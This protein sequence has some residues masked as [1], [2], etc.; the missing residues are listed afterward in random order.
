MVNVEKERDL[1]L[2]PQEIY[3]I[4]DLSTKVS[5]VNG[6]LNRFL[7]E[8]ALYTY[9]TIFLN[10]E[11]ENDIITSAAESMSLGDVNEA[12]NLLLQNAIIDEMYKTYTDEYEYILIFG[13]QWFIDWKEYS[14]SIAAGIGSFGKSLNNISNQLMSTDIQEVLNISNKWGMNENALA[15]TQEKESAVVLDSVFASAV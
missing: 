8:R 5:N 6:F 10:S 3:D 1:H 14:Q 13:E 11:E 4:L 9:T 12:W 15:P 2:S 7:Y